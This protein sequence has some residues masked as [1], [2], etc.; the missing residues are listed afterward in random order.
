[1]VRVV[2]LG[3]PSYVRVTLSTGRNQVSL[4]TL[5]F[6]SHAGI[7]FNFS[8]AS[9]ADESEPILFPCRTIFDSFTIT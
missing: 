6:S 1:M 7:K 4:A 9:S 5:K 3:A 2:E 8:D